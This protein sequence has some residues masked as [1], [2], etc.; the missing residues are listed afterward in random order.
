MER[1]KELALHHGTKEPHSNLDD[2]FIGAF[3]GQT[4]T[5]P[6]SQVPRFYDKLHTLHG[7]FP[8]VIEEFFEVKEMPKK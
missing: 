3:T 6:N 7:M 1:Q 2:T 5:D 4:N 8:S